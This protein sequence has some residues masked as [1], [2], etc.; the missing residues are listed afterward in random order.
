MNCR[1]LG[2]E[3]KRRDVLN[4]LRNHKYDIICLQ[5]THFS[6]QIEKQIEHEWGF[7][8]FFNSFDSRSRGVA[9]LFKNSFEFKIID[10]YADNDGNVL[11]LKLQINSQEILLAC[12]YGPNRDEPLF[13]QDLLRRILNFTTPNIIVVGDWNIILNPEIDCKNYKNLN[14]PKARLEVLR[15]MNDLNLFDVWRDEN[16]EKRQYTWKRKLQGG[17]IQ[18]GRLD[19]FLISENLLS[20]SCEEKICT[21]YRTDHS[22]VEIVLNFEIKE[23]KGGSFWKFN[24]SLLFNS[25]FVTEANNK[26]LAIQKQY[27]APV[28]N[29]E[30]IDEVDL[31]T[32]ETIINPQLF[33]EMILLELRSLSISF[34]SNLKKMDNN[35]EKAIENEIKVLENSTSNIESNYDKITNLKTELQ[36]IREKRLRGTLI[37]SRARWVEE[38][39][40]P[41]R[42]FLNLENRNFVSKR[43]RS[44]INSKGE[45]IE[46]PSQIR[47]EVFN[48][49]KDLYASREESIENVDLNILL[50]N[51]T[52]KLSDFEALSLEGPILHEEASK[53]LKDM[54]NNKSPGSS[55][56]TSEFFKF[57]WNKLGHIVVKSI[58]YSFSIGELSSTQK[59]GV[60]TCIPKGDKSKKYLKNWRPISLLNITY[61]IASGCIATR[62]K[63]VLPS[64]I[65]YDQCGFMSGRFT[66][67]NIR[68]VYDVLNYG[69]I[70]Q[71]NGILLLIDFEKAFDSVAWSF[72]EKC[73]VFYNFKEDIKSW[74]KLFYNNIKS[75]VIVNNR[76]TPWFTV[77]RGCRQGDPISPYIFLLCSE[78]LAHMVRQNV[79]I[80]GYKISAEHEIKISQY[81]D[82]TSLFLDGSEQSFEACVWTILEYAKYSGLAM[83]FDKTKVIWFGNN[84]EM[85]DIFMPHLNFVWNPEK[86]NILGVDFTKDLKDISDKNIEKKLAE[87]QRDIN[88][89]SKRDLTPFGRITVIKSLIISKIVHILISLPSPSKQMFKRINEMLYNFLWDGKPDKI[90]R[91]TAKLNLEKGGLG[92]IDIE[93]FDK[94]LKLTWIRRIL[95]ETKKW[96]S[97]LLTLYPEINNLTFYGD[98]FLH[99]LKRNMHNAFWKD[100]FSYLIDFHSKI[101]ITS[102]QELK[103]TCFQ[104]NNK[105]K[106]G[107]NAIKNAELRRA[108]IFFI[109]QLMINDSFIEHEDFIQRYNVNLDFLTYNSIIRCIKVSCDYENL[110]ITSKQ[111]QYQPPLNAI[112][113]NKKGA[114]QIYHVF[115]S[116]S[117]ESKGKEKWNALTHLTEDEWLISFVYLKF[118]T[119]DTKLRW[120]Q[121]RI[122]HHV[123]TTN[124]SVS[125]FKVDQT[126]LCTFCNLRS[127]TIHHLLWEC[128]KVREFWDKLL[129]LIHSR[130]KHAERLVFNEK[131]IIFGHEEFTYTDKT[132][133]QMI[134]LAK[135]Y[136][137]RC[138]VQGQNLNIRIFIQNVYNTYCIEKVTFKNSAHFKQKW[139]LYEDIFKSLM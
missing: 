74:I 25:D 102:T 89:W 70:H 34:S 24:N 5:D 87:M 48:F 116:F 39:E 10:Q 122:L 56:F 137:Y 1:G 118:S 11:I 14:N 121:F 128:E 8:T 16:L 115:L 43:M 61:K 111:L 12:L 19:Y 104:R 129:H 36:T 126:D 23:A 27:A 31:E 57:F 54:K 62:I 32:F 58:N 103:T 63:K 66:G 114:S 105:F 28:Y 35:N 99:H 9:I 120:L 65:D 73:L 55:G 38:G 4:Y 44:I 107:G 91:N 77:E 134:L 131:L 75:S 26:I 21:G 71:Q 18:M 59:E 42:Y 139:E 68:L 17:E 69:T 96:R 64:I 84:N 52:P 93:L 98:E 86:F 60:I 94:S 123:L 15:L 72:M 127:E 113:K 6:K 132:L 37:R 85:G 97:L 130:C 117:N 76:P 30:K 110:E 109:N 79:D 33:L 46:N 133:D 112:L 92:M 49:Y 78:V 90:K 20:Y 88:S 106:I 40:K 95:K 41:S 47:N 119:K 45:E 81:A 136:I 124:R 22:R 50:E 125:K 2:E 53:I 67:D 138:K 108:N 29:L 13:Y 83:N 80:K 51:T 101:E 3:L 135:M 82:D 100:T 7:N